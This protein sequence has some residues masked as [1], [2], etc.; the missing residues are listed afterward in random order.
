MPRPSPDRVIHD[1]TFAVLPVTAGF[2]L[3]ILTVVALVYSI[4]VKTAIPEGLAIAFAGLA[5][6]LFGLWMGGHLVRYCRG[7]YTRG[8][9]AEAV[10]PPSLPLTGVATGADGATMAAGPSIVLPISYQQLQQQGRQNHQQ[11]HRQQQRQYTQQYQSR[12]NQEQHQQQQCQQEPSLRPHTQSPP[13]PSPQPQSQ[14]RQQQQQ[15]QQ[16]RYYPQQDQ[17]PPPPHQN[18]RR[19]NDPRNTLLNQVPTVLRPGPKQRQP[20]SE[21]NSRTDQKPSPMQRTSSVQLTP[22]E[23]YSGCR[24]HSLDV[25]RP[26]HRES[27]Q[28]SRGPPAQGALSDDAAGSNPQ[29]NQ[30]RVTPHH[31]DV[32]RDPRRAS[33][34]ST[35]LDSGTRQSLQARTSQLPV[36]IPFGSGWANTGQNTSLAV[37]PLR[38]RKGGDQSQ[39][40][41]LEEPYPS[42]WAPA[43]QHMQMSQQAG[44]VRPNLHGP[45]P[46]PQSDHTANGSRVIRVVSESPPGNDTAATQLVEAE[47][48]GRHLAPAPAPSSHSHPPALRF[49]DIDHPGVQRTS[50]TSTALK[51]VADE[52][53]KHVSRE[54]T[55]ANPA[56]NFVLLPTCIFTH[57]QVVDPE[58][59]NAGIFGVLYKGA[60]DEKPWD[61]GSELRYKHDSGIIVEG[62]NDAERSSTPS[63]CWSSW[64]SRPEATSRSG[65]SE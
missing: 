27:R 54:R 49:E 56:T 3:I 14:F 20:P 44:Q 52:I 5:Y 45:R 33:V 26:L 34:R 6:G 22:V 35:S 36:V 29:G 28:V 65:R 39:A 9:I 47:V 19:P 21:P 31:G 41:S 24:S 1:W 40:P 30:S 7:H 43:G 42:A 25:P 32:E 2:V 18:A 57:S 62:P 63:S 51:A 4:G 61:P 58:R 23:A 48:R 38:I 17:Q 55:N 46:Q 16:Q 53:A 8:G 50:Q 12:Q 10:T 64:S 37:A 15:Q 59:S 11:D 13:S 60:G